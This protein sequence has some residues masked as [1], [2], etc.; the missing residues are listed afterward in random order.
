[1]RLESGSRLK[2][3][4]RVRFAVRKGRL[5]VEGVAADIAGMTI[6]A[7]QMAAPWSR[8]ENRQTEEVF[9]L[10][11][12]S[13]EDYAIYMLDAEGR[14]MTWNRGAEKNKGYLAEEILGQ[15]FS[16]FFTPEEVAAGVPA[17]NLARARS[18]G[19]CSGEGWRVRK[20]GERFWASFVLRTIEDAEG[21]P[22]GFSKV[23]RNLTERKLHEDAIRRMEAE[24]RRERDRLH[25][26]SESSL[27]AFYICEA[28]RGK[29]GEIEDFAFTY[30]NRNAE[31][32]I[33]LPRQ[34]MLGGSVSNLVPLISELGFLERYKQVVQTGQPFVAEFRIYDAKVRTEWIRLQAVR[35]EDGVAITASDITARKQ[36]EERVL[37][38]AQHD[39]LTGLPNRSLLAD[40]IG[41]A[42][43]RAKRSGAM[44]CICL[45]DLDGFKEINDTLGHA[46]GDRVLVTVAERIKAAVR[47]SDSV[48]RIGGDEFVAVLADLGSE[49]DMLMCARKILDSVSQP[50]GIG[51]HIPSLTCSIG[52]SI[53]PHSAQEGEA[54][55]TRADRA[56]YKIKQSGKNGVE[57]FRPRPREFRAGNG[58]SPSSRPP[59]DRRL[60]NREL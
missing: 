33:A 39:A 26:A 46:A 14:V 22:I 59:E 2:S 53:Y 28:V 29:T 3:R 21:V 34:T 20:N 44:A 32:L 18:E 8:S 25:A 49:D 5:L 6:E 35:L 24:V 56:M 17:Q 4:G 52:I 16:R 43:E 12:D 42:I 27:D 51:E 54:L 13:I 45:I 55:V 11:V 58:V 37:H 47:G 36:T 50:I 1:M 57:I 30:C 23:T 15:H 60:P 19:V 7:E 9:R 10:L 31:K 38:L 40:R 41:M 48:I